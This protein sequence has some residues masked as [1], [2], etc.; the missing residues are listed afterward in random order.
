MCVYVTHIAPAL[1][2]P[3]ALKRDIPLIEMPFATPLCFKVY[4]IHTQDSQNMFRQR[5]A[6]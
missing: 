4:K 3:M 5:M 1:A 6:M 2:G